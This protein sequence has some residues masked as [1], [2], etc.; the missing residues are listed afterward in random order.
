MKWILFAVVLPLALNIFADSLLSEKKKTGK[1]IHAEIVVKASP[2]I[3]FEL[4]TTTE[5]VKKFFG[6]DAEIENKLGGK[7]FV[8]FDPQDRRLSSEGARI[9]QYDPPNF[10]SFEWRGKPEMVDMNVQ[11]FPTWVEVQ[12]ENT[13]GNSTHITLDHY[14]FGE[15][16][17]WNQ[18]YEFFSAAW[19]EVLKKLATLF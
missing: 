7:Y 6:L 12:F 16:G 14:G 9:L 5:G 10:L 4:W 19:P 15:S 17:T 2:Q 18:S 13:G 11:P 1:Q 8:Y 3:V